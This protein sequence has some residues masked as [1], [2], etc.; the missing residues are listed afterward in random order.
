MKPEFT[1]EGISVQTFQEIY[2][3]LVIGYKAIYGNDIT[4]DPDSPDGQRLAI[5]AQLHL[6]LQ[7]FA[8]TMYQQLDPDFAFGQ[9]QQRIMK[10]AGVYIRPATR[11]QADVTLVTDRAINPLVAG[12]TVTD[13]IGQSWKTLSDLVLTSG[14]NTITLFSDLFGAVEAG[15]DTI[16][17]FATF[18]DG[19]VS[20]TNALAA[21]VGINEETEEEVR[22]RRNLSLELPTS[23][24]VGRLYSALA[25]VNNVTGLVIYENDTA[26]TDSRSIPAHSLWV[27]VEGGSIADISKTMVLNKTGGKPLFGDV[28]G[29][30]TETITRPDGT[31][32]N[33]IHTMSFDR[34]VDVP[35]YIRLNVKR[36]NAANPIDD[37]LI[38]EKIAEK[39]FNIGVNILAGEIY[40]EIFKAGEAF[41]PYDVEISDDNSTFTDERILSG[42]KNKFSIDVANI[43]VTE[44]T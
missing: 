7:S 5:E 23:S 17:E 22:L 12:F 30:Y 42:L 24:G 19:V 27:V 44:I 25:A 4:V 37:D 6:D 32:F 26:S 31:T 41:I 9:S 34:P 2:D 40:A 13:D 29:T 8:L 21:T 16:T 35:L 10:L 1:R 14:S 43:T 28:D 11:S 15:P 38:K 3:E 39:T 18:V 36:R 33:Y 20:V